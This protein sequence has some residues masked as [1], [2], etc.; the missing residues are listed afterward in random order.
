VRFRCD[1]YDYP[2][3]ECRRLVLYASHGVNKR[4]VSVSIRPRLAGFSGWA[5]SDGRINMRL[6]PRCTL[7]PV[8]AQTKALRRV[9]PSIPC[10]DW[11]DVLIFLS[12]HEFQHLHQF[13]YWRGSASEVD[14]DERAIEVLNAWRA[15]T[16]RRPI[17]PLARPPLFYL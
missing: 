5:Y 4:G 17:R 8:E 9:Y 2:P 14:A 10:R 1:A 15:E 11:R 3:D 16:G 12:A 6:G 13:R 7:R